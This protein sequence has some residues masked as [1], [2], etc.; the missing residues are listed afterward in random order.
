[1]FHHRSESLCPAGR[2]VLRWFLAGLILV[3]GFLAYLPKAHEALHGAGASYGCPGESHASGSGAH[4]GKADTSHTKSHDAA[5]SC[6]VTMLAAGAPVA[7][8]LVTIQAPLALGEADWR[9]PE[10]VACVGG[11]QLQPPGRAPPV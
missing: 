3:A 8:N 9:M 6:V 2:S 7:V 1:M 5:H 10:D 4:H 11:E